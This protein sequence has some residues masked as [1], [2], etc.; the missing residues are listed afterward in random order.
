MGLTCAL[1]P[2]VLFQALQDEAE[3][4]RSQARA[5]EKKLQH[6]EL[7]AHMQVGLLSPVPSP[8]ARGFDG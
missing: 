6:K 7:Q 8:W 5:A 4:C 2:L 1:H 3:S